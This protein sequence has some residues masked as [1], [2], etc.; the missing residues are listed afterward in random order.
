MRHTRISNNNGAFASVVNECERTRDL[1]SLFQVFFCEC[2]C[3]SRLLTHSVEKYPA[4]LDIVVRL[5]ICK[6]HHIWLVI[7]PVRSCILKYK[8]HTPRYGRPEG[9]L[10]IFVFCFLLFNFLNFHFIKFGFCFFTFQFFGFSFY[11]FWFFFFAFQFCSFS[12]YQF[13]FTNLVLKTKK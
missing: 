9:P 7:Q 8:W 3:S 13:F 4:T 2:V 5:L 10:I 11:P 12:F 1:S 6:N